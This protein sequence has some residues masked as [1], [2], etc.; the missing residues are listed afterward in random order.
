VLDLG[1][2]RTVG[3]ALANRMPDYLLAE[4]ID[5][6]LETRCSLAGAVLHSDRGS[7]YLSRKVRNLLAT[8]GVRQSAGRVA[9]CETTR[10]PS[11]S[12]RP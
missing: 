5:A 10:C 4:A 11:R 2:R 12:S 9:T 6:A 7:Q 3:W 8:L 1:S